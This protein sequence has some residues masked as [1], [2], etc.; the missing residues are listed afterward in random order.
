QAIHFILHWLK[1]RSYFWNCASFDAYG[2][3]AATLALFGS[4]AITLSV[5]CNGPTA[6]GSPTKRKWLDFSVLKLRGFCSPF[7][8]CVALRRMTAGYV[9]G[10]LPR[11]RHD[12]RRR[13]LARQE[14]VTPLSTGRTWPVTMRDSSLA[15]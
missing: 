1:A 4:P 9:T 2:F 11:Q 5:L 10:G 14:M 13:S 3:R 15:R 12:G 6:G 8:P 7:M